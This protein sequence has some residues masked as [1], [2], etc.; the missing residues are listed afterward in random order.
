MTDV[1]AET[2]SGR[3]IDGDRSTD[4]TVGETATPF[5]GFTSLDANYLYC[6]N[7]FLDVC[8]PHSSRGVVRLVAYLLDQTLGWL[9]SQGNPISQNISVSYQQ[10]I[11]SAGISRSAIRTAI[12]EAVAAK[13][14]RCI[15]QGR[16][17]SAGKPAEQAA[18]TL[19]WD[20]RREYQNT[21]ETFQGFF[22]GEG[23]RTP[24][25]NAFFRHVIPHETLIVTKV[26]GTV[27]RHTV[28]YQ[29]QFGGRRSD[30]PL[31]YRFIQKYAHIP[32]PKSLSQ[33]ISLAIA[34]NYIVCV[35]K[36]QFHP[37]PSKRKPAFYAICWQQDRP[38][39]ESGSKNQVGEQSKI[40]S[41][42]AVQNPWQERFD[43]PS[44]GG[45]ENPADQRSKNPSKERTSWKD[46]SKQQQKDTAV[47]VKLKGIQLLMEAGF[48]EATARQLAFRTTVEQIEHQIA[49]LPRRN[50]N[51][52][53]LG[54]LRRAIAE[55]WLEPDQGPDI[56]SVLRKRRERDREQAIAED[57]ANEQ[58]V[59]DKQ[60]RR[61]HL[62]HLKEVWDAKS[63]DEQQQIEIVA[64]E[65][66]Q[67]TM[68]R[69]LFRTR[70]S[71]RL[72][73]CLVEL[74]RQLF[75]RN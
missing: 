9:D 53:R 51:H 26:I 33:G 74:D 21:P 20:E 35:D 47:A 40:P 49:W 8:L 54:M 46:S 37:S 14:I 4:S 69:E 45:S 42:T 59:T 64:F 16:P 41:S 23:H 25:P 32:D 38:N 2:I 61:Q 34:S 70:P 13:Y 12:D 66:Q 24:I 31:S 10:L 52:N 50:P 62:I 63:P 65:H 75:G 55:N 28:G 30:A 73:E 72:R 48:D 44:R 29:N 71:H 68:L 36:G 19:Q 67:G 18:Y 57:R 58:L 7:Q 15:Q 11:T 27:L 1:S 60:R 3:Y 5:A 22:G 43:N 56:K 6:P 39:W 17:A